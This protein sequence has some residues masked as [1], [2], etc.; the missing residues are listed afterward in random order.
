MTRYANI[1]ADGW[2]LMEVGRP[3]ADDMVGPP[4]PPGLDPAEGTSLRKLAA[5][6]LRD[7]PSPTAR[8]RWLDTPAPVWVETATLA[9]LKATKNDEINAARL[10]ANR[11][12]FDFAGK[13]IAC[14]EV[15]MLDIQSV[16]AEISLT[17]A[18][19]DE[20]PGAWKTKDNT[21]APIPDVA[22]WT[23]FIKAMVSRGT[24]HFQR[25]QE[26]KV[27]LAAATTAEEIAAITW[28][29]DPDQPP[30]GEV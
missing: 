9:E 6:V 29:P 12:Y 11:S 25:A 28:Q 26:L 4:A 10:L 30:Q 3:D 7:R 22:T 14:D 17:H 23:G 16:N 21:Y 24:A 27:R 1:D 2:L 15:S 5:P 18:M 8:A 19:P 13:Q 20:W